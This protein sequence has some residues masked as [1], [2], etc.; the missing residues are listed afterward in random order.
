MIREASDFSPG[1]RHHRRHG[2]H[3]GCPQEGCDCFAELLDHKGYNR[4]QIDYIVATGYGR[5]TLPFANQVVTEI[6]CHA[7]G[8]H[9]LVPDTGLVIDVGGQDS[10]VIEVDHSGRVLNFVMNDKCVAQRLNI[11]G[12]TTFTERGDQSC[13]NH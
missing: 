9:H 10:K 8:A 13:G 12:K 4:E 6:T 5:I 7:R 11:S 3:R 2:A 1:S